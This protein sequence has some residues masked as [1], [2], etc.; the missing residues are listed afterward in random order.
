MTMA[1]ALTLLLSSPPSFESSSE[2]RERYAAH[3]EKRRQLEQSPVPPKA[4]RRTGKSFVVRLEGLVDGRVLVSRKL[5]RA[6]R[7]L[8]EDRGVTVVSKAHDIGEDTIH[9]GRHYVSYGL[10]ERYLDRLSTGWL[11]SKVGEDVRVQLVR[12]QSGSTQIARIE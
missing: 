12:D 2:L 7:R 5:T 9:R 10:H 3:A 4:L 11:Q 1:V 8:L 6:Q